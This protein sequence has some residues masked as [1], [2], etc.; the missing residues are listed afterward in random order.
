MPDSPQFA[1]DVVSPSSIGKDR[2]EVE[3]RVSGIGNWSAIEER[4][5]ENKKNKESGDRSGFC[6]PRTGGK[7]VIGK[8]EIICPEGSGLS[9]LQEGSRDGHA[10]G[11]V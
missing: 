8:N 6:V 11:A 1:S 4:R 9:P 2:G 10:R 3:V 5:D 7:I